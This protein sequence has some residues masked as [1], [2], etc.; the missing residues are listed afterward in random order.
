M[1][2]EE[3]SG[4]GGESGGKRGGSIEEVEVV[5][6]VC[7]PTIHSGQPSRGLWLSSLDNWETGFGYRCTYRVL[8]EYRVSHYDHVVSTHSTK[9]IQSSSMVFVCCF[10]HKN[11]S[12][13]ST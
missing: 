2:K 10:R 12:K 8:L 9:Y 6:V 1:R 5:L 11:V 4:G 13:A 7:T 3:S